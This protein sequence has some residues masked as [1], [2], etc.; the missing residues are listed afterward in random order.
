[1]MLYFAYE[2]MIVSFAALL[3]VYYVFLVKKYTGI[4]QLQI[5]QK[6]NVTSKVRL[7]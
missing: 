2:S 3:S 7:T 1:M 4:P 6:A 5:D